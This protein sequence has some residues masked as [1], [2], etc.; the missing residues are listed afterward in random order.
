MIEVQ[1]HRRRT[2]DRASTPP[3][4][5]PQSA[6]AWPAAV[7][8]ALLLSAALPAKADGCVVLLCLAGNWRDISECRAPVRKALRDLA[9]GRAFP[10][11]GFASAPTAFNGALPSE[12]L[13]SHGGSAAANRWAI[14]DFCPVQ[15]RQPVPNE[16]GGISTW[17]CP[18]V[19]A[20]E[21]VVAG[22]PW[23]RTW[24]DMAG[25]TVTEWFAAGRSATAHAA[26]D[27][28]FERDYEAW[29][30]RQGEQPVPVTSPEGGA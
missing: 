26:Q 18:F 13:T 27:N 16:S 25:N 21:L 9:L 5:R 29:R 20:I 24:W 10:V 28:R 23:N 2:R 12:R 6:I 8:A 7:T 1:C 3:D 4:R 19:G 14:G 22:Q 30:L 15:Y 11:C 17:S